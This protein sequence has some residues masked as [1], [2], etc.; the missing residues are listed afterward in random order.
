MSGTCH[1][2][3]INQLSKA[4]HSVIENVDDLAKC[5]LMWDR[6][7][8]PDV[9]SALTVLSGD[10]D[11]GVENRV[12]LLLYIT[13]HSLRNKYSFDFS[14]IKKLKQISVLEYSHAV[15]KGKF[16]I[17]CSGCIVTVVHVLK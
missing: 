6:R 2:E 17:A 7:W 5:D 14:G 15:S 3:T 16:Y 8:L 1:E 4:L 10:D 11:Q 9:S 13:A 12:A